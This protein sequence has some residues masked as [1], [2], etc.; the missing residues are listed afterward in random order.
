MLSF[1]FWQLFSIHDTGVMVALIFH[2]LLKRIS[3]SF[4][5]VVISFSIFGLLS[6]GTASSHHTATS[7]LKLLMQC[8]VGAS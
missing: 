4:Q 5:F 1:D 7:F 8:P 3:N 6:D 2:A